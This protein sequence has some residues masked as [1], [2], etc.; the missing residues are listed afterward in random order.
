[1]YIQEAKELNIGYKAIRKIASLFEK[2]FINN[3]F[4]LENILKE[5][6][7]NI[8]VLNA[9]EFETS[10]DFFSSIEPNKF[11]INTVGD[12]LMLKR[13]F[14]AQGLGHYVLHSQ[15]GLVPC[16]VSSVSHS[17]ASKE[18][19]YFS[20]ALLLNDEVIIK[21]IKE[22]FKNQQIANFFRVPEKIIEIKKVILKNDGDI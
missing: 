4:D 2:T 12:N 22:G 10:P 14:L 17:N 18:G 13:I 8:K 7:A 5:L 9:N 21:M 20:L 15:R 19:F 6:G 11:N 3:I 16:K 1:M